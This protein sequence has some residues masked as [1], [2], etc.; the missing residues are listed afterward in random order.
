MPPLT[1]FKRDSG[2]ILFQFQ[3]YYSGP[4]L[5]EVLSAGPNTVYDVNK[6]CQT[7]TPQPELL[8]AVL[9]QLPTERHL[10]LPSK[11]IGASTRQLTVSREVL[12]PQCQR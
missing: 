12:V 11:P 2:A 9:P 7:E 5:L 1:Y 3:A 10:W 6:V 4:S 8:A